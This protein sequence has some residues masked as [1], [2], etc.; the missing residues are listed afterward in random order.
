MRLAPSL[1]MGFILL[2][3][4]VEGH[5]LPMLPIYGL[6]VV[7]F[8]R[9]LPNVFRPARLHREAPSR[10]ARILRALGIVFG[11]PLFIIAGMLPAV[12]PVFRLPEPAGPHS[13]G[14][15][16]LY[17]VDKNRPEIF[18]SDPSDVRQIWARVWYP[19]APQG[20]K[21]PMSYMERDSARA[22]ARWWGL[23]RSLLDG[24]ALVR[25]HSYLDAAILPNSEPFPVIIFNHGYQV[26]PHLYTV[27][28]EELA[29]QGYVVFSVGHAHETPFFRKPDG[30]YVVFDPE[31]EKRQL[32]LQ[33]GSDPVRERLIYEFPETQNWQ[34]RES[35]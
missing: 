6:T 5:R 24:F 22:L 13:V 14:C 33:E 4:L 27:M 20:D 32:R 31:N 16:H 28:M 12:V 3:L 29:S 2:H 7:L 11:L 23:P 9:S 8:L 19:A 25:T 30:E 18:T 34:E 26:A 1:A 15:T 17:F 21:D 10:S 35:L